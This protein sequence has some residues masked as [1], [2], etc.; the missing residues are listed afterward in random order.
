MHLPIYLDNQ[1]TTPVD[2]EVF[3]AMRPYFL[4]R[5]GNASSRH[6]SYGWEAESAVENSRKIIAGFINAEPD[7]IYF[8]SG[9]TESINLVHFGVAEALREKGSHI[10]TRSIE[11][12]AV[13]DSLK[14]LEKKGFRLTVLP[15]DSKGN[16][17]LRQLEESITGNTILVSIMSANNEIGTVNDINT[18]GEICREKNVLFHT[19]AA[20]ALG[21]T[22][23]DVEKAG[24]SF[25]SFTAHK[26]YGPKGIGAVYV[27]KHNP[28]KKLVP[29]LFGGGQEKGIRPGTLNVPGIV[30]FGKAV[31][32]YSKC[33]NEENARIKGLRD[34]LFKLLVS[35]L[36]GVRLN[37]GLENRL[38]NNLNLC[39]GGVKSESFITGLRDIA[40]STGSA[41]SS[42]SLKPSRV[43]KA[44]GLN[45]EDAKSSV[46][47]G[48]GRFNTLEEIEYAASKIVEVVNKLRSISPAEELKK[49]IM[50]D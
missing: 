5:F 22:D 45:D 1:S 13:L 37:G 18:I 2:P 39:F 9:A 7:E 42:S 6:H 33:M 35:Y 38:P 16:I 20:Q 21:K 47:F 19:D 17:S 10:I 40:V 32:K 23:F 12:S 50:A 41:C 31:E 36:D 3:E 25:T 14:E 15:V 28:R 46:R 48:L 43:L 11:H 27:S 49:G 8:T 24:I 30:G 26:I 29:R 34:K 4:E 44:I